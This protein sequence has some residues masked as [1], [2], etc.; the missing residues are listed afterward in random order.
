MVFVAAPPLF[1]H[2]D[3]APLMPHDFWTTWSVEPSVVLPIAIVVVTYARGVRLAW[4]KA[5]RGRGVRLWQA[6]LFAGGMSALIAALIWPLDALGESL[7]AAHMVQHMVLMGVAAPLI[8]LGQ[9]GPTMMRA[10]PTHWQ[11][12][13]ASLVNSAPWKRGWGWLTAIGTAT[14]LQVVVFLIWHAPASIAL[15][16]E[17][18]LVHW[19]MHCSLFAC[20]ILFWTAIIRLRGATF[21]AEIA[22]LVVTFKFS[23]IVGALIGFAP[24]TLYDSYGTRAAVWGYSLLEDQQMAGILMMTA[25]AMMYLLATVILIA[26]WLVAME[27]TPP[28]NER[29]RRVVVNDR[30]IGS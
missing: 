19:S 9:P 12:G 21:G 11:R 3:G 15:S 7:F 26:A 25:G 14:V 5:G 29:R 16:L 30:L 23:L 22:A 27:S 24:R 20:A 13:L 18:H 17:N 6:G 2:S 4:R 10:L 1:A 28:S 8:I